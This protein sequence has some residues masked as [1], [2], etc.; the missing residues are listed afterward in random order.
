MYEGTE[1][2][3]GTQI[4][5]E[6][7]RTAY[8]EQPS[9]RPFRRFHMIPFWTS[10]CAEQHGVRTAACLYSIFRQRCAVPVDCTSAVRMF[11]ED[12]FMM[13]LT[14][15]SIEHCSGTFHYFFSDAVTRQHYNLLF[16]LNPSILKFYPLTVSFSLDACAVMR[17]L[18]TA[19][20]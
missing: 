17:Y 20:M 19:L 9:F 13:M 7:Q 4:C 1:A 5:K 18:L 2:R 11:M 6:P 3:H 8:S 14:R 12:E 15:H 16:H 10:D